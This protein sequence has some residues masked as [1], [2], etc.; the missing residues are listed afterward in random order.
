MARIRIVLIAF[1]LTSCLFGGGNDKKLTRYEVKKGKH[2]FTP[3]LVALDNRELNIQ[4]EL[5]ASCL[6]DLKDVGGKT[7]VSKITGLS[8]CNGLHSQ[9]AIYLGW[10]PVFNEFDRHTGDFAIYAY[11]RNNG[12][13]F[14]NPIDTIRA[15]TKHTARMRILNGA[16]QWEFKGKTY[17]EKRT[18][19]CNNGFHYRIQPYFG[20]TPTTPH[21]MWLYIKIL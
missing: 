19:K 9:N 2:K 4:F 20:G 5:D 21:D 10:Q 8:D 14:L 13:F 1:L 15:N 17:R 16:Y 6:Y 12:K 11:W 7:F 18:K 3:S